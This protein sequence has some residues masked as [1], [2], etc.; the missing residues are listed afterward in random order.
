MASAKPIKTQL[1][2]RLDLT[3]DNSLLKI[4]IIVFHSLLSLFHKPKVKTKKK[5]E[6]NTSEV[7]NS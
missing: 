6:K 4:K 3:N 5:K 1:K 2:S 7:E